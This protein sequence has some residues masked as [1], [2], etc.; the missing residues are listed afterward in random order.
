MRLF[1]AQVQACLMLLKVLPT[2]KE[3]G[4]WEPRGQRIQRRFM[5]SRSGDMN[6]EVEDGRKH[7]S[8]IDNNI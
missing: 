4:V 8:E 5:K 2:L 6:L 1:F 7:P 3:H